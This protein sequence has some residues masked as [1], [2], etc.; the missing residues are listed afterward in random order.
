MEIMI[1]STIKLLAGA[2]SPGV[3][4]RVV[5]GEPVSKAV[6]RALDDRVL[7]RPEASERVGPVPGRE[8]E[9]RPR[10]RPIVVEDDEPSVGEFGVAIV[11]END[12]KRWLPVGDA[13]E[14]DIDLVSQAAVQIDLGLEVA[15][16]LKAD[17]E[18]G[19]AGAPDRAFD[20]ATREDH[21]PCAVVGEHRL[22][23]RPEQV[24]RVGVDRVGVEQRPAR[25]DRVEKGLD[26]TGRLEA[27]LAVQ[28]RKRL[29]ATGVSP[30][31]L[32]RHGRHVEV[33]GVEFLVVPIQGGVE[34]RQGLAVALDDP[35]DAFEEDRLDRIRRW[36]DTRRA[37]CRCRRGGPA[38]E[39]ETSG[40]LKTVDRFTV[41]RLVSEVETTT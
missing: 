21:P 39:G 19:R 31:E 15:E 3:V 33:R 12:I 30:A 13:V 32:D 22:V 17:V 40:Y 27:A 4:G 1:E 18:C 24:G 38:V 16:L 9:P 23:D 35:D 28:H 26:R 11:V 41:L 14:V 29:G 8:Q 20:L 34:Q 25:V 6:Q 36:G 7:V 5:R 2:H 10:G 37:F